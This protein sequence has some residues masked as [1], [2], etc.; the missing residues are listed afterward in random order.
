[1]KAVQIENYSQNI[2]AVVKNI[3]IPEINDDEIL[4]KVISAAVNPLDLL[5]MKGSIK[6]IQNYKTI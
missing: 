5:I 1:M 3:N 2:Q 6:L 4:I